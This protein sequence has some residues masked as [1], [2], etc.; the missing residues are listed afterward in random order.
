MDID[1]ALTNGVRSDRRE[2]IRRLKQENCDLNRA[3]EILKNG[4]S[5]QAVLDRR[6]WKKWTLFRSRRTMPT[7]GA[8]LVSS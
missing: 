4:N 6:H 2:E 1:D 7:R 3:N 5:F 8:R